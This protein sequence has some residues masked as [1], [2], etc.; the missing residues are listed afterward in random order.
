[1]GASHTPTLKPENGDFP[2][3]PCARIRASA[4]IWNVGESLIASSVHHVVFTPSFR[5]WSTSAR[6][7]SAA[8]GV[9]GAGNA[10]IASLLDERRME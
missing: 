10:T 8:S 4:A 2:A 5:A 3:M 1:M 6:V 9:G 7:R